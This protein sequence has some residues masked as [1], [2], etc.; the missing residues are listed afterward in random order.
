M[1][2]MVQVEALKRRD[3]LCQLLYAELQRKEKS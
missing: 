1:R 2:S 3:L